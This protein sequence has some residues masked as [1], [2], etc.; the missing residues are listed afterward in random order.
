MVAQV[1][2]N[3]AV[4]ARAHLEGILLAKTDVLFITGSSLNGRIFTQTACNL[5]MAHITEPPSMAPSIA[6]SM[7][8]FYGLLLWPPSMAPTT[9]I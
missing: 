7:A 5:Q 2:G 3:V 9:D 8:S 6:P 4:S 1:S